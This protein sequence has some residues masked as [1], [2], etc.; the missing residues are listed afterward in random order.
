MDCHAI[1][2]GGAHACARAPPASLGLGAGLGL[3][4]KIDE[5]SGLRLGVGAL[6]AAAA[7]AAVHAA[8]SAA[9][10][11]PYRPL[12]IAAL[13]YAPGADQL[14][15]LGCAC[16]VRMFCASC[17]CGGRAVFARGQCIG[18]LLRLSVWRGCLSGVKRE[19]AGAGACCSWRR[20]ARR[21]RWCCMR[22]CG[23]WRCC[24]AWA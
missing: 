5:P 10:S 11:L 20:W 24:S 23:G 14:S 22:A 1:L 12:A 3:G 15:G 9:L 2:Q 4:L 13:R 17:Q 6:L 7:L 19:G 18:R 21:S 16:Q 8:L